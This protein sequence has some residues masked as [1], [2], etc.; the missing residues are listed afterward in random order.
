[1][2]QRGVDFDVST[3]YFMNG[4]YS[5][6]FGVDDCRITRCGYTGEDGFEISIPRKSSVEVAEQ[7]LSQSEVELAGLGARDSLRLE[8]GLCLYGNDMDETKTPVEANLT[9]CIGKLS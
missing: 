4:L 9:W 2:L 6:L 3:L 8:A 5:R 7:I 1:M